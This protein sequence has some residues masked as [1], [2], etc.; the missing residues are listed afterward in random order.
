MFFSGLIKLLHIKQACLIC[1]NC[2]YHRISGNVCHNLHHANYGIE[3]H[4][5]TDRFGGNTDLRNE[6]SQAYQISAGDSGA[7]H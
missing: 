6:Q 3:T 5:E 4:Y 2:R 1:D 7:A